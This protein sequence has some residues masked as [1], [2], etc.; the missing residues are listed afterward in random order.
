MMLQPGKPKA[1]PCLLMRLDIDLADGRKQTI[2]T[3]SSWQ[4]TTDGPI[5]RS[6]IYYGETYDGTKELPG[7]DRPGFAATGW[8]PAQVLPF[9]DGVEHVNLVRRRT[10]RSAWKRS[11]GPSR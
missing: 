1:Q 2:L 8:A 7:W 6:G 5:R 10:N 3:D 11:C 4:A 9:P